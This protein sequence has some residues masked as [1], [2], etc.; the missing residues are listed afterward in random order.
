M[1]EDEFVV[2][3]LDFGVSKNLESADGPVTV[4]GAVVGSPAYMSPEQVGMRKDLDHRT[5][6]W[7]LGIVLYEMLAGV[8]PFTGSVEDVVRQIL[9]APIS[10]VSSRVRSIS[11]ELD[12]IVL[13]CLDRDRGKRFAHAADL[14]RAL[15]IHAETSKSARVEVSAPPPATQG[16]QR[17]PTLQGGY[18]APPAS[19][20]PVP[21]PP[22][23]P[24]W[25]GQPSAPTGTQP[26]AE[27]PRK[28]TWPGPESAPQSGPQAPMG[29]APAVVD[30]DDLAA[31]LPINNRAVLADLMQR[32]NP[33]SANL[34]PAS[35]APETGTQVLSPNQPL[36]SPVP[37]W[38]REMQQALDAHRQS[39]SSLPATTLEEELHGGTQAL[40]PEVV[41]RAA[42]G[43]HIGVTT[44]TGGL[45]HP[46]PV[47]K[48]SGAENP[49]AKGAKRRSGAGVLYAAIAVGVLAASGLGAVLVMSLSRQSE[50]ER[51]KAE[52]APVVS[53]AAPTA[54]PKNEPPPV[55]PTS[56][57]QPAATAVPTAEPAA[58]PPPPDPIAEKPPVVEP[59]A[60]VSPPQPPKAPPTST[61][62]KPLR[63]CTVFIK[64]NCQKAAHNPKGP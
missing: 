18:G 29:S 32:R 23:E 28:P 56:D 22:G 38:R 51:T 41:A 21:A 42:A 10:P 6:I 47:P 11:P 43:A 58:P 8:R 64:T 37:D 15:A 34:P 63:P 61:G 49:A 44:S 7:S 59:P 20:Q 16:M 19:P 35:N 46:V 40:A 33:P 55:V 54:E 2:K 60:P 13:R 3:V 17:K 27:A 26:M 52:A 1:G 45:V 48:A 39:S 5:D 12:E 57:V 30:E 31:T 36:P 62:K 4:T 53:T 14:A 24:G 25:T 9:L 50:P